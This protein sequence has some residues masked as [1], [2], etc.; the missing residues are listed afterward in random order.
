MADKPL[1][2]DLYCGFGTVSKAFIDAGFRAIG[3]D[4]DRRLAP[5]YPGEFIL[6]DV[7]NLD[8]R[9]FRHAAAIWASP[10]CQQFSIMRELGRHRIENPDMSCV[11]AAF[12]IRREAGVPT[13]IE[14]VSG[15]TRFVPGSVHRGSFYLWGDVPPLLITNEFRKLGGTWGWSKDRRRYDKD[16]GQTRRAAVPYPLARAL[17]EACLP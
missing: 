14:N 16:M 3:F 7:R 13:I 15:L 11:D 1:L 5:E 2:V 9:R 17:A 8:G 12:R 10:P 4:I 6:A